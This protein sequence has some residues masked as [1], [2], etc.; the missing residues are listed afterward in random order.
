MRNGGR[1]KPDTLFDDT[2]SKWQSWAQTRPPLCFW[3]VNVLP[4]GAFVEANCFLLQKPNPNEQK[5]PHHVTN[6][7][8]LKIYLRDRE[9]WVSSPWGE[10]GAWGMRREREE[11]L[12]DSGSILWPWHHDLSWYKESD[13]NRL[14]RPG[15]PT[16][17][18]PATRLSYKP[19]TKRS[20]EVETR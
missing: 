20:S 2:A 7:L 14:C 13:A 10:A 9:V 4:Y 5:N 17:H 11:A 16:S 19:V 18:A 6:I 8:F 3:W 12:S 1:G 15:A